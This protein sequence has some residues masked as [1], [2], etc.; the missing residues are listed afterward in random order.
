[1]GDESASEPRS[2]T[3][4]LLVIVVLGLGLR[5]CGLLWGLPDS[6]QRWSFH[7]DEYRIA[8]AA[9]R[10]VEERTL[11]P[12]RFQYG[13]LAVYLPAAAGAPLH[14]LGLVE[15]ARSWHLVA[16]C[17]SLACSVATILLT[18]AL[19]RRL[20]GERGALWAALAL[21]V[22]PGAVL[23]SG[24]ATPDAPSALFVTLALWASLC[25][26]DARRDGRDER[27]IWL[28]AV[29]GG[30]AA[31]VKYGVGAVVLVPLAIEIFGPGERPLGARIGRAFGIGALSLAVFALC[32]PAAFTNLEQF[33]RDLHYELVLHPRAGHGDLF[34]D[35][36]DGWSYH[37]TANLPYL[38]GWPLVAAVIV[39][40]VVGVRRA[41]VRAWLPFGFALVMFALLGT[42]EV[43]FM[44]YLTPIL[45]ALC[46]GVGALATTRAVPLAAIAVGYALLLSGL[47]AQA[48]LG[49]DPRDA[50]L[51]TAEAE[52]DPGAAIGTAV[53]PTFFHP[54]F[55]PENGGP[56]IAK[57]FRAELEA[58][59]SPW[60]FPPKTG[61]DANEL[62]RRRLDAF[63]LSEHDWQDDVRLGSASTLGFLE[64]LDQ[65]FGRVVVHT[66]IAPAGRRMFD[67]GVRATP[68]DWLYPFLEQ[69]L[70]LGR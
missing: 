68:H 13:S 52:L 56:G 4:A 2:S 1:M 5:L 40:G 42:S 17:V 18:W 41:G 3:A 7:P 54:P 23:L 49:T 29:A 11:H 62:A 39:G 8:D 61:L 35:T 55:T 22:A 15:G 43:R 51:A 63:V 57:R 6:D 27:W 32:M 38:L 9:A 33:G 64:A 44:R 67:W 66:G 19:A 45:P 26:F 60:R 34:T 69:R 28:A 25:A 58:G 70:Y 21:A 24:Y 37:L 53:V 50:L 12:T 31:A 16:R 59:A 20:F 30:L 10:V 46:V 14:A 47:Q 65:R 48:L 36:G